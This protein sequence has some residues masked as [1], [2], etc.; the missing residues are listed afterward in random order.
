MMGKLPFWGSFFGFAGGEE[1]LVSFNGFFAG[2][3]VTLNQERFWCAK[4]QNNQL[5]A[6]FPQRIA[7]K[8]HHLSVVYRSISTQINQM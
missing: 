5:A 4:S 3:A 6:D 2:Q 1:I 7:G 8:S